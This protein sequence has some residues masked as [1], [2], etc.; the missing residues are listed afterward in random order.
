LSD[1]EDNKTVTDDHNQHSTTSDTDLKKEKIKDELI[2]I[3]GE[4][5]ILHQQNRDFLCKLNSAVKITLYIHN[6][7]QILIK[8]S[9]RINKHRP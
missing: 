9:F 3:K 1:C 4:M 7:I 2:S 6:Y 5:K 8:F